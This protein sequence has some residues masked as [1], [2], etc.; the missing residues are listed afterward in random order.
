MGE[1]NYAVVGMSTFLPADWKCLR[2]IFWV[3]V[4]E[5]GGEALLTIL[6]S[7]IDEQVLGEDYKPKSEQRVFSSIFIV[8]VRELTF[9]NSVCST[10]G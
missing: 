7:R 10:L 5:E 9:Q 6:D 8:N 3:G 1:H 2:L 4:S